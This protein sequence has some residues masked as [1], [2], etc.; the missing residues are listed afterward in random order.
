MGF[1]AVNIE[2]QGSTIHEKPNPSGPWVGVLFDIGKFD[3]ALYG[4]AATTQLFA[5]VGEQQLSGCV[6]HG[7]DLLPDA[8]YWCIAIHTAT[9]EQCDMIETSVMKSGNEKLAQD[10]P[11]VIRGKQVLVDTLPFQ[12]FVSNNGAYVGN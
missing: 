2:G 1:D 9:Q 6:V 8:R 11:P 3:E 7:G 4:R 12:G 10:R 5:I